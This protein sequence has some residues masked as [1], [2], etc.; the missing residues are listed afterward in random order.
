MSLRD[1]LAEPPAGPVIIPF[2]HD[3]AEWHATRARRVG[4]SEIAAL[5][6]LPAADRPNYLLTRF[7][8]WHIKAGHAPAPKVDSPR[9]KWGIRLEDV[10]AEA[11][12]EE[13]GW[14]I[15]K[16]GYVVDTTTPGLGC[17]LDYVVEAPGPREIELGFS[18]PGVMECKNLDW[19]A[20]KRTW[21][22]D[23][24]P[25]H[26]LLQLQH[27][28][29]ATGYTW[30][31]IPALIGGNNLQIYRY[32]ARPRLIADIR[33]RV[34]EFWQSIDDGLEPPVDGS[35][36]SAEVLASLYPVIVD[37]ALD[38]RDNNEWAEAAHAFYT[39][40]E[41]RKAA[42]GS[43]EDAKNRVIRLLDGHKRGWGNGWSVNCA[44]TPANPGRAP[45]PGEVIGVK[46]EV[47]R[48]SVKEMEAKL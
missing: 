14:T 40:G 24:P 11:A 35:D 46:K 43:Y 47:R 48:Y 38:M 12:A 27:Q 15:H 28:L 19:L 42:N 39:A 20:H 44:I 32:A 10:I 9:P 8:L 30:G 45:R 21:T 13:N 18:G 23:E 36:G 5:F 16:G 31:A 4:G 1:A 17:T 2:V 22:D 33:R 37:D 41:D 26:T 34:T 7:A 6:D 25:P 3:S 29:A